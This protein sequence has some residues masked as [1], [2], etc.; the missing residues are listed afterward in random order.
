MG[1][2]SAAPSGEPLNCNLSLDS[3]ATSHS[4]IN[5]LSSPQTI[6]PGAIVQT[7]CVMCWVLK[8]PDFR[9]RTFK[10]F[11]IAQGPSI[12][13]LFFMDN[14]YFSNMQK[15]GRRLKSGNGESRALWKYIWPFNL[16]QSLFMVLMLCKGLKQPCKPGRESQCL[17][18]ESR[19]TTW[20]H[21]KR[22]QMTKTTKKTKKCTKMRSVF[23][24]HNVHFS[25]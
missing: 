22:F 21:L 23:S 5:K 11:L 20:N 3:E 14:G 9:E 17:Q 13:P 2:V 15:I 16:F 25:I 8:C 4:D 10:M 6:Y 24:G 12:F 18:T 7:N 19:I 1:G